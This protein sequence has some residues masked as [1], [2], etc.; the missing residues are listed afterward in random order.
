MIVYHV[1]RSELLPFSLTR[2][3]HHS[4]TVRIR[5]KL[6]ERP[7]ADVDTQAMMQPG[8]A[9]DPAEDR[10]LEADSFLSAPEPGAQ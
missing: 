8:I 4:D 10:F 2:S 1:K 3:L 7:L 5:P 6:T 9:G